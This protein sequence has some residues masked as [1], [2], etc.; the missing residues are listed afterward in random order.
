MARTLEIVSTRT[1]F[2]IL[3]EAFYGATRFEQFVERCGVSEPVAAARLRELTED[4]LLVRDPYQDPGQRR[5]YAYRLTRKG[6]DLL[7]VI[8]AL[9]D[10]GD[11]WGLEC[12]A[13]VQL[14]HAGC[15]AAVHA[16]LAC[17]AGH[18]VAGESLELGV[19]APRARRAIDAPASSS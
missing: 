14:R 1:A 5:R 10:W 17:D 2:L 15:G 3:R 13:R 7:P 11:R 16:R 19:K 4:G 12:G 6:S 18:D 9:F 8:V